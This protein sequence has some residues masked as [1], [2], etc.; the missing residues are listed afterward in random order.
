MNYRIKYMPACGGKFRTEDLVC[1]SGWSKSELKKALLRQ[2]PGIEIQA[3]EAL[4]CGFS[5][6]Q[7]RPA[8]SHAPS[9]AKPASGFEVLLRQPGFPIRTQFIDARTHFQAVRAAMKS[10]GAAAELVRATPYGQMRVGLKR[11]GVA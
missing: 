1:P 9:L 4:P 3:I 6:H 8:V 11:K 5:E 7:E 10:A 2:R